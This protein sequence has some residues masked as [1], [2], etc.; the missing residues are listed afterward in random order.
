MLKTVLW[1]ALLVATSLLNTYKVLSKS[2]KNWPSKI[3]VAHIWA[4]TT[5]IIDFGP[6]IGQISIFLNETNFIRK[7]SLNYTF[8]MNIRSKST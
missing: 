7:V 6:E 5:N 1:G 8:S 4:Y 2:D 3:L